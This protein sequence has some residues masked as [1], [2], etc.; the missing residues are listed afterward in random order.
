MADEA[1]T[2]VTRWIELLKAGEGEAVQAVWERFFARVVHLARARLRATGVD[3]EAVAASAFNSFCAAAM[4]GRF[5][6]LDDRHD[7]WQLLLVLT[8]RKAADLVNRERRLKRGGGGARGESALDG[9]P[10]DPEAGRGL[11]EVVG[12]EP[13]PQFAA[14]VAEQCQ[15]LLGALGDDALRAVAVW[16]MEGHS[17]PEIAAKLGCSLSSVERKLRLVRRIWHGAGR[18]GGAHAQEG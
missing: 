2:S 1:G 13:T 10:E 7:L 14:E 12:R 6:R 4:K 15:L 11:E 8:A 9:T 17:N 5:P 3:E 18:T 16:K